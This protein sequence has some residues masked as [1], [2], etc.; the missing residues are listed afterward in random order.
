MNRLHGA[1]KWLSITSEISHFFCCGLPIVFSLLSLLSGVGLIATMPM[2]IHSLHEVMHNYEMPM[3]I[4]SGTV[5]LLGWALHVVAN[6][7]DCHNTGCVHEPCGS[8]K[9]RSSKILLVATALYTL[10]L[11]GYLLLHS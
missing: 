10:N 9:K 5:I 8:K 6:K 4:I 3:I 7:I 1:I 11:V 2:G